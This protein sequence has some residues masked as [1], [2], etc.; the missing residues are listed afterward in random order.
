MAGVRFSWSFKVSES[1]RFRTLYYL[2]HVFFHRS[3]YV[4]VRLRRRVESKADEEVE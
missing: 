2:I 3:V 1:E 4:R